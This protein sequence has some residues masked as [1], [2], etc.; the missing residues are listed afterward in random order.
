MIQKKICLLGAVAVGKTSMVRRFVEGTFSDRYLTTIGV[1]IVKKKIEISS[2]E[3]TLII[4]D[5]SGEDEFTQMQ[6][7]Y[8]RGAAGC[9][10]VVDGTRP[11]T[12]EKALELKERIEKEYGSLPF[13]LAINKVDLEHEWI[14][15]EQLQ[16]QLRQ[17]VSPIIKTSAK[18]GV[19]LEELFYALAE[20]LMKAT[21]K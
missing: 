11:S 8:L 18:T 7:S 20:K 17:T 13:V 6:T 3:I 1:K 15:D 10:L 4:W 14:V 9:I 16:A 2:Q 19:G 5:L 12:L 21:P